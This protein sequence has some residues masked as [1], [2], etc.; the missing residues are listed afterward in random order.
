MDNPNNQRRA[1]GLLVVF[2]TA[3]TLIAIWN[4]PETER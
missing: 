4:L 3:V 2:A 1:I